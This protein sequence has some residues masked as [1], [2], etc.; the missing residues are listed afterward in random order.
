MEAFDQAAGRLHQNLRTVDLYGDPS[1]DEMFAI[2][3]KFLKG[4]KIAPQ[5]HQPGGPHR[6]HGDVPVGHGRNR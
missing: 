1:K 4:Y 5:T 2:R 6:N 3:L